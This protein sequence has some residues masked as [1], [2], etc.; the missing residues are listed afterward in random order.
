MK[1]MNDRRTSAGWKLRIYMDAIRDAKAMTDDA[2]IDMQVYSDAR[3]L[4]R[5]VWIS[6][7]EGCALREAETMIDYNKEAA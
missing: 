1:R 6:Y 2:W 4:P 5:D 7:L 3:Y